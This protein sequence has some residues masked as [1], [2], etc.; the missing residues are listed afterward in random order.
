[1]ERAGRS[2]APGQPWAAVSTFT[3]LSDHYRNPIPG[4]EA[5]AF[6]SDDN[7]T[8]GASCRG[9]IAG[10][11]PRHKLDL[12]IFEFSRKDSREKALE[13]GLDVDFGLELRMNKGQLAW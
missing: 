12:R 6:G 4:G 3:G 10:T 7:V 13:A 5:L 9:N 1:M 11:L 8:I 2:F